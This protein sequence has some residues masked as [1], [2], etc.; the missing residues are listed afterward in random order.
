MKTYTVNLTWF[1]ILSAVATCAYL[2]GANRGS[3]LAH[4]AAL[5]MEKEIGAE[6]AE[7][8]NSARFGPGP[9]V[10]YSTT[11]IDG[12]VYDAWQR[13]YTT[14]TY[15]QTGDGRSGV[16]VNSPRMPWW[17]TAGE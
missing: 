11:L 8:E 7:C 6:L 10:I 2:G 13:V 1:I 17:E 3:S 14:H 12:K 5:T 4:R 15:W 16:A 9:G